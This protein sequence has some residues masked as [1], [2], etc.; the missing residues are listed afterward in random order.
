MCAS[1]VV[2]VSLSFPLLFCG[3][4]VQLGLKL[5]VIVKPGVDVAAAALIGTPESTRHRGSTPPVPIPI[6]IPATT[7]VTPAQ[8]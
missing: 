7:N 3:P 4:S 2:V 6:L 5:G 8:M 1:A